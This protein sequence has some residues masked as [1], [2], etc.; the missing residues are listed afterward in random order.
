MTGD[1]IIKYRNGNHCRVQHHTHHPWLRPSKSENVSQ[2]TTTTTAPRPQPT[3]NAQN[4]PRRA[5]AQVVDPPS[6]PR[7]ATNSPVSTLH[8]PRHASS[9]PF[10]GQ[11]DADGQSGQRKKRR[12][13][14]GTLALR[15]I[16][17]YQRSTDLLLR[18]L[19]FSRVVRRP[20]L[21]SPH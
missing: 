10:T 9:D 17:K 2:T 16:R 6:R 5:R 1:T 14:P 20:C 13:R 21:L 3:P 4:P 7:P 18:K 8:E 15:E 19:P 11:S 12:Y